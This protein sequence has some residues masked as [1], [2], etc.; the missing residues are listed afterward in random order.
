[1]AMSG[2]LR[3]TTLVISMLLPGVVVAQGQAAP[4]AATPTLAPPTLAPPRLLDAPVMPY[5]DEARRRRQQGTV[6]L[7]LT[8]GTDG[9]V[10]QAEVVEPLGNELDEAARAAA[11]RFRFEPARRDGAPVA[12]RIRYSYVFELP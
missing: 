10:T 3:S 2:P 7:R 11:L 5:P 4:A 1:M 8:I 6:V 12:A 9:A